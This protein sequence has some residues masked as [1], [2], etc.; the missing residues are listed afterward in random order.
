MAKE[1]SWEAQ[2]TA[3]QKKLEKMTTSQLLDMGF[4][5]DDAEGEVYFPILEKR[6][7]FDYYEETFGDLGKALTEL[8]K[9]IDELWKA[10]RTHKHH[11]GRVVRDM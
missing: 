8:E 1:K 3:A 4:P 11:E 10:V 9:K 5:E 2:K 6:S 7:P